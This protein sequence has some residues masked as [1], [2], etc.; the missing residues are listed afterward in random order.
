MYKVR[1]KNFDKA[2]ALT[3]APRKNKRELHAA[4]SFDA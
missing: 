1:Q 2:N 4:S 3:A